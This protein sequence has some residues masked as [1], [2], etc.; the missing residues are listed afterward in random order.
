MLAV[1]RVSLL[2]AFVLA[3]CT[4]SPEPAPAPSAA[5]ASPSPTA[6]SLPTGP[7]VAI[8][9]P[10]E[11]AVGAGRAATY[12]DA[13][14]RLEQARGA[15]LAELRVVS[16]PR[17]GFAADVV[18][19][20]AEA[21]YDLVCAM[22]VGAA[23]ALVEVAAEY[24]TTRF[25]A[26]PAV[27]ADPPSNLLAL[28]LRVAEPAYAVG[29][30]AAEVPLGD[31]GR[32]G[33]VGG[34]QTYAPDAQRLG[35]TAGLA[36]SGQEPLVGF[37]AADEDAARSLTSAQAEAGAVVVYAALGLDAPV[38]VEV[39]APL[40]IRVIGPAD[41]LAPDPDDV[42]DGILLMIDVDPYPAL[43]V[44]VIRLIDGWSNEPV[45]VGFAEAAFSLLPGNVPEAPAALAAADAA[46]E[47]IVA[48]ELV[49]LPD[50]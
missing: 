48:G 41:A 14:A 29:V 11:E 49:P 7:R 46:R 8:V 9:L 39:A 33:F 26:F 45:S 40:G 12:R 31:E 27:V 38:V 3:A 50:G 42:P 5:V 17:P 15:E 28:D 44:A 13:V 16:A 36:E 47:A 37:P 23:T 30:G 18:R 2:C 32:V 22:G 35:F 21:R 4:P 19:L 10:S 25:C 34:R 24:P 1:V 6:A 43:S 20:L